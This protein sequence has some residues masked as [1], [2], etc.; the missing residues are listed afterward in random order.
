M[1]GNV[2]ISSDFHLW[3]LLLDNRRKC[4]HI[5]II[6]KIVFWKCRA[7]RSA[8]HWQPL[9]WCRPRTW[10]PAYRPS[11]GRTHSPRRAPGRARR[12]TGRAAA[13]GSCYPGSSGWCRPPQQAAAEAVE[14]RRVVQ[15][16]LFWLC[17]H[18][19]IQGDLL[20]LSEIMA[21]VLDTELSHVR[22]PEV[23]LAVVVVVVVATIILESIILI[24]KFKTKQYLE[25]A[26]LWGRGRCTAQRTEL[27]LLTSSCLMWRRLLIPSFL[28]FLQFPGWHSWSDST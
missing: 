17:V 26:W 20:A 4:W 19:S 27:H 23:V 25:W 11:S 14:G 9:W 15:G 21:R 1:A 7:C 16:D 8:G 3:S 22:S 6:L 28:V 5:W 2:T 13:R 24:G 18:K 10:A 12:G